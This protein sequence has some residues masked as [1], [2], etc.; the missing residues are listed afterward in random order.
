MKFFS[1]ILSVALLWHAAKA[2]K[3]TF[4]DDPSVLQIQNSNT[5]DQSVRYPND[6][7]HISIC[8]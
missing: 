3:P 7:K 2:A 5:I 8:V 4:M 1:T 6:S